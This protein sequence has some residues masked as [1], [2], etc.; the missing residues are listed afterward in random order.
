MA[1]FP[2]SKCDCVEDTAL[3]R[4][5]ASRLRQ[6]AA[7]CSECDPTIAKWHGEFPRESAK[8]W[9]K[10]RDGFLLDKRAVERW[11]GLPI[12]TFTKPTPAPSIASD[13]GDSSSASDAV[14]AYVLALDAVPT[15][16]P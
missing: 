5:W 8:G 6:T 11:L 12:D 9:L 16:T 2:C 10:D 3:C 7:L 14:R 15:G 4:Y 13:A 1:I